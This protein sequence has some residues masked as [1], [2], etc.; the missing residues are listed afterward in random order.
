[1][2]IVF[3]AI[4]LAWMVEAMKFMADSGIDLSHDA[5]AAE[6][7]NLRTDPMQATNN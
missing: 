7:I 1:M 6:H 2:A 5:Y 4:T 3:D